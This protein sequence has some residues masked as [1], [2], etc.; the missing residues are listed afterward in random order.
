MSEVR[1]KAYYLYNG[2]S[3]KN[4]L[5]TKLSDDDVIWNLKM[6][7]DDFTHALDEPA[8]IEVTREDYDHKEIELFIQANCTREELLNIVKDVLSKADLY[9]EIL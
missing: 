1:L 6:L 4:P 3:Q 2:P 8:R 9:G 5:R 7:S